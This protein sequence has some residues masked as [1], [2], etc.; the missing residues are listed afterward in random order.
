MKYGVQNSKTNYVDRV[1]FHNNIST[2]VVF[3]IPSCPVFGTISSVGFRG[4]PAD[5]S[6]I[7]YG[8]RGDE[9]R[10]AEFQS[11]IGELLF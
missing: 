4:F 6:E 10:S 7:W 2:Y 8:V 11:R 3:R 5:L 9:V 1:V